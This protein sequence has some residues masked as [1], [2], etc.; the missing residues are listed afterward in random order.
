MANREDDEYEIPLR[1]QRYFGAGIKRKRV[2]FVAASEDAKHSNSLPTTP[3]PSSSAAD[4]YLS[5]VLGQSNTAERASSAPVPEAGE[6]RP[7]SEEKEQEQSHKDTD[8]PR[9]ASVEDSTEL[10]CNLCRRN[11]ASGTSL[12][13]HE[14]SIAHQ[15]SLQHSHPPS[16]VDRSRKGLAVL[17]GQGWDPDSRLGLGA[18]GEGM[19]QPIKAVENPKKAGV[20]AKLKP[21]I[22]KEKPVKLDAGKVRLMEE[23]G[24]KKAQQLRESFYMSDEVQ[25]HL[26]GLGDGAI[27]NAGLDM[28]AF[29][30]SK[31]SR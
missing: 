9:A 18:K 5:I 2:Q 15:I 19:L 1:D 25:K 21:E 4:R 10:Y 11:I 27:K 12:A 16:H 8:T 7:A 3:R 26:G 22:M 6:G 23:N 13:A 28:D 29:K 14:G 20:G 24:K 17:Q 31:R 30:R